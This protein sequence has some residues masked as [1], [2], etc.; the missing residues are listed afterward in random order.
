LERKNK[1]VSTDVEFT[2]DFWKLYSEYFPFFCEFFG[3]DVEK[4][5]NVTRVDYC[6]DIAG[7]DVDEV[8][9]KYRTP[10]AV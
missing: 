9:K 10:F 1:N 7:I 2:G 5:K 8:F 6:I 4:E 3:I